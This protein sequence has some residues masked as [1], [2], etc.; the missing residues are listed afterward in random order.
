MEATVVNAD[1][2][3]LLYPSSLEEE[4][5]SDYILW[6]EITAAQGSSAHSTLPPAAA[7]NQHQSVHRPFKGA[8]PK[9][10]VI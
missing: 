3:F 4:G 7:H 8:C 1:L 2:A 10:S 5:G 9:C 6:F